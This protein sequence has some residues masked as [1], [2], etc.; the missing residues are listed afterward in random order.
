MSMVL[1]MRSTPAT[2]P[3]WPEAV[4][5]MTYRWGDNVLP[6]SRRNDD[7]DGEIRTVDKPAPLDL[8]QRSRRRGA[9]HDSADDLSGD[10]VCC[11]PR[12]RAD[13]TRVTLYGEH[14]GKG[15][16]TRPWDRGRPHHL[17]GTDG[18]IVALFARS[19][20]GS[21]GSESSPPRRRRRAS[22]RRCR[23]RSG[24]SGRVISVRST[25]RRR[26]DG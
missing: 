16:S 8:Q 19:C 23:V 17:G 21:H 2:A 26:G 11:H 4:A 1:A 24:G 3:R 10:H 13:I 18:T 22:C 25:P 6:D 15:R 20:D 7:L 14:M 12:R 5:A 9:G